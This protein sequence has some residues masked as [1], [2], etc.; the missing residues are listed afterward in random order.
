MLHNLALCDS[1]HSCA[2]SSICLHCFPDCSFAFEV[3]GTKHLGF[4]CD[5]IS[6]RTLGWHPRPGDCSHLH[7]QRRRLGLCLR[8]SHFRRGL[9]P[10]FFIYSDEVAFKE[11]RLCYYPLLHQ[12]VKQDGEVNDEPRDEA[13]GI[14]G[15]LK[16]IVEDWQKAIDLRR[17]ILGKLDEA[18]CPLKQYLAVWEEG[19]QLIAGLLFTSLVSKTAAGLVFA[20]IVVSTSKNRHDHGDAPL[21]SVLVRKCRIA[22][23]WAEQSR[24]ASCNECFGLV[25]S[26]ADPC[27]N[28]NR[29][30]ARTHRV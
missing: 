18:T 2:H 21:H 9:V 23:A 30:I 29:S 27:K 15:K 6:Q 7:C 14:V 12:A 8:R 19:L 3:F 28:C 1:L 17:A 24:L 16:K 13:S 5:A 25:R 26:M 4:L 11:L 20:K 22:M 10:N